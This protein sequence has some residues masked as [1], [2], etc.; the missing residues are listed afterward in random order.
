MLV[1][2]LIVLIVILIIANVAYSF[3]GDSCKD[4]FKSARDIA[5]DRINGLSSISTKSKKPLSETKSSSYLDHIDTTPNEALQSQLEQA[6]MIRH[7]Q[8]NVVQER[9]VYADTNQDKDAIDKALEQVF[10]VNTTTKDTT[11]KVET[12]YGNQKGNTAIFEMEMEGLKAAIP[13]KQQFVNKR[14]AVRP[15]RDGYQSR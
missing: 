2:A 13:D 3:V 7:G 9:K 4:Y 11:K 5:K 15:A 10:N 14:L 1:F 6:E 12:S 8:F